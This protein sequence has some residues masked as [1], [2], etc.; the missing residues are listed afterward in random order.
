MKN[1]NNSS[2]KNG[3]TLI[4]L[5]V[6]ASIMGI[7]SIV[8]VKLLF[9]TVLG[10]ARQN[11][12]LTS[13]EDVRNFVSKLTTAVKEADQINLVSSTELQIEGSTCYTF[14]MESSSLKYAADDTADCVPPGTLETVTD[15]SVEINSPGGTIP[16]IF[17]VD[18]SK[19]D[20]K[21]S[22]KTKDSFGNHEFSY[23]TT[24]VKRTD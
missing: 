1:I 21:L 24:V 12:I 5:L 16:A 4:E 6:A 9:S 23:E 17:E 3:F 20:L 15:S 19:V 11:S 14:K 8:S 2:R 7:I 10:R 22:G 18:D 13:S